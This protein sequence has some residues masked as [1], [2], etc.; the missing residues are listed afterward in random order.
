MSEF[1]SNEETKVSDD[2]Q[3]TEYSGIAKQEQKPSDDGNNDKEG[4]KN[5]KGNK[6]LL[7]I[8]ILIVLSAVVALGLYFYSN[9]N[10]D[11]DN[12]SDS[13]SSSAEVYPG[14]EVSE[15]LKEGA[16]PAEDEELLINTSSTLEGSQFT[17]RFNPNPVFKDGSSEGN[18][19]LES[20]ESNV[21]NFTAS[22]SVNETNEIIYES[23]AIPAGH[24]IPTIVLN[25]D[26]DAGEYPCTM[27][28]DIFYVETNEYIASIASQLNIIIEK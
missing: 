23:G 14:V 6:T 27:V 8:I 22:I 17:Y 21:Y 20:P 19:L 24:Y 15:G 1:N 18:L 3:Q 25:K 4:K 7:V 13:D 28:I 9:N 2:S 11:S 16:V 5:R 12:A 26:L 10:N